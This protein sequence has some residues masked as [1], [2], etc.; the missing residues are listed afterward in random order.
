[1]YRQYLPVIKYVELLKKH[2]LKST[3]FFDIAHL[4]FLEANS[5]F[6]DFQLQ[7]ELIGKS[8]LHILDNGMEVQLHIH[9]QWAG[10]KFENNFICVTEKWNIGQLESEKQKKLF[11]DCYDCIKSIVGKS[12]HANLLNSFKAGAWALQPINTLYN[13]FKLEGI[14]LILGPVKGLRLEALDIDYFDLESDWHPY[15][16]DSNDINRIGST[17]E[18]VVVPMSPT[19]LNWFD[20]IR[21]F[22]TRSFNVLK[23]RFDSDL[24][25]DWDT[26]PASIKALNPLSGKDKLNFSFKPFKTYMKINS[27]PFWY[28]RNT[29]IRTYNQ[30]SKTDH[31]YKLIV[32]ETHTKDFKNK[33]CEIDRFFKYLNENY[34]DLTFI[35]ASELVEHINQGKLKPLRK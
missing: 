32:I 22:F 23:K 29:F 31:D 11:K 20:L 33:F 35:T 2:G 4:L 8:I 19:Y 18:I 17:K 24:D 1:M 12:K 34:S 7:A 16:C 14:K 13:E 26:L 3:F 21:Y 27:Q 6:K 9:S 30:I 28:L 5:R 10:A 15:Y 25:I